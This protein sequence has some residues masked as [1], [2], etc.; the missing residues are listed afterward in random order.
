VFDIEPSLSFRATYSDWKTGNERVIK[1]WPRVRNAPTHPKKRS[2][3]PLG[4][5]RGEIWIAPDFD[6]P[7]MLVDDPEAMRLATDKGK[8]HGLSKKRGTAK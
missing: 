1:R 6:A 7:L 5:Y 4:L 3:R 8:R 2:K